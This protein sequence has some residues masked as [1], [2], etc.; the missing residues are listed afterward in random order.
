MGAEFCQIHCQ[1]IV[2]AVLNR[3]GCLGFETFSTTFPHIS[4]TSQPQARGYAVSFI[5]GKMKRAIIPASQG[6]QKWHMCFA[7]PL[8]YSRHSISNDQQDHLLRLWC[9]FFMGQLK[10]KELQQSKSDWHPSSLILLR[11]HI[12][13]PC[14]CTPMVKLVPVFLLSVYCSLKK[15]K[16]M[17][18]VQ[19]AKL[20]NC[21]AFCFSGLCY[22]NHRKEGWS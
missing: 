21:F 2:G 18:F 16:S 3:L 10:V 1:D 14:V 19:S 5:S 7:S 13:P 4:I 12:S 15:K 11:S 6:F 17:C 20:R 9:E 8:K 22:F